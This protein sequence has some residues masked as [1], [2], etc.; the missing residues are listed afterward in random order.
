MT[1]FSSGIRWSA[2]AAAS[3]SCVFAQAP[4]PEHIWLEAETFGPLRGSNFSFIH[5]E[6]T[7]T[8]SWAVSGPGVADA[9]SQGGESEWMSIAVRADEATEVVAGRE[10]KVPIAGTYTLWVRYSDYRQ[11]EEAFG[12]RVKQGDRKWEQ[13]LRTC[14]DDR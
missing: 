9:W 14:A 10:F 2:L 5:P 4:L 6:K 7:Q 13:C 1:L 8:G 11:K 3:L 12:V